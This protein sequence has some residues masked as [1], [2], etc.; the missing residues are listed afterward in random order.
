[1]LENGFRPD[2]IIGDMDSI[3]PD[4][5]LLGIDMYKLDDQNF[6]DC[7]KLL[8][9]AADRGETAITLI[10]VEGDRVDHFLSTLSSCLKSV[11]TVQLAIRDG[12]GHIVRPGFARLKTVPGRRVSFLPL[13]PSTNVHVRGVRWP[14]TEQ[15]LALDG[16]VSISNEASSSVVEI[17]FDSGAL[18][19]TQEVPEVEL[20]L[21][22]GSDVDIIAS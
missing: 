20:P 1:M 6:T 8:A 4:S 15:D 7:D 21:W 3:L 22:P 9:W 2:A 18:L 16:T 17:S 11:L 10:G 19:V 12:V 13:V 14:L 5:L